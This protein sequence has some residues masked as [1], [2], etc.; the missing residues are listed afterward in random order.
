MQKTA[1]GDPNKPAIKRA[2]SSINAV[3]SVPSVKRRIPAI[4]VTFETRHTSPAASASLMR[5]ETPIGN[6]AVEI[7]YSHA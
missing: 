3:V 1:S 7:M 6:P 2:K 4:R 5:M